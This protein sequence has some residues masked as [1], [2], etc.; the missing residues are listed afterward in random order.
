MILREYQADHLSVLIRHPRQGII[1]YTVVDCLKC[2]VEKGVC[3][4][5]IIL[6]EY[7]YY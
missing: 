1:Y 7:Y 4:Q 3:T 2:D 6:S 5:F